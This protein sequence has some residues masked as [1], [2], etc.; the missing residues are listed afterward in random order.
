MISQE[1][2]DFDHSIEMVLNTLRLA[3]DPRWLTGSV[4]TVGD[5]ARDPEKLIKRIR[6]E[7]EAQGFGYVRLDIVGGDRIGFNGSK[8]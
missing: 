5:A 2:Q 8:D 6:E 1:E 7:A 3:R 4:C